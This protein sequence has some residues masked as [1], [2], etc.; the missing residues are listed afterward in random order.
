MIHKKKF[1]F[2]KTRSHKKC[3]DGFFFVFVFYKCFCVLCVLTIK[4]E[5]QPSSLDLSSSAVLPL[6]RSENLLVLN[7]FSIEYSSVDV[8]EIDDV[9]LVVIVVLVAVVDIAVVEGDVV[10]VYVHIIKHTQIQTMF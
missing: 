8:V 4:A 5:V 9:V 3:V 10:C 7:A 6:G 1:K 2:W